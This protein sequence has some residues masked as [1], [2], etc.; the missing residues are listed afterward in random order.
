MR[1]LEVHLVAPR[2][3][4]GNA[5]AASVQLLALCEAYTYLHRECTA[6]TAPLSPLVD[7]L[8]IALEDAKFV[9]K[10]W[11]LR[12]EGEAAAKEFDRGALPLAEQRAKFRRAADG[13]ETPRQEIFELV[14]ERRLFFRGASVTRLC[15]ALRTQ[16]FPSRL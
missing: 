16:L 13:V 9:A 4:D 3:G 5:A 7:A 10:R 14:N 6:A 12:R 11:A 1:V 2:R 15:L 8:R